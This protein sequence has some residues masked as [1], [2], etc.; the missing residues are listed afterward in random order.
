MTRRIKT[1]FLVYVGAL[2]ICGMMLSTICSYVISKHAMTHTIEEEYVQLVNSLTD[3]VNIWLHSILLTCSDWSERGLFIRALDDS[4]LGKSMHLPSNKVLKKYKESYGFYE[5]ISLV[6]VL[7]NVVCSS[8]EELIENDNI[9]EKSFFTEYHCSHSSEEMANLKTRISKIFK[10]KYTGK[11]V[12][13][14]AVPIFSNAVEKGGII[15]VIDLKKMSDSFV[16]R[17]KIGETGYCYIVDLNGVVLVHPNESEIGVVNL[18]DYVFDGDVL[19]QKEGLLRYTYG[20]QEKIVFFRRD[21]SLNWIFVAGAATEEIFASVNWVGF[22]NIMNTLFFIILAVVGITI[23]YN[24]VIAKQIKTLI[25][26]IAKYTQ[27]K[28]SVR[29]E[30]NFYEEFNEIVVSFNR[31]ADSLEHS[32]VSIEDLEVS[33]RRFGDIVGATG[34][35]IWELDAKGKYTYSSVMVK[36]VLGYLPEE[37]VGK[38]CYEFFNEETEEKK[39]Q[40]A[41]YEIFS[42]NQ[43]RISFRNKLVKKNGDI[44]IVETNGVAIFNTEKKIIGYR[45]VDRDITKRVEEEEEKISLEK[46]LQQ[47]KKLESI[48]TLAAGIAHEIN[49]PIQFIGDNIHFLSDGL[50]DLFKLINNFSGLLGLATKDDKKIDIMELKQNYEDEID[51]LFLENEVPECIHQTEDGLARVSKIVGAM[52]SFSHISDERKQLSDI[53]KAIETA[54]IV[55]SNEWKY[56]AEIKMDFDQELPAVMCFVGDI[57]QVIMNMVLNATH[58]IEDLKSNSKGTITITTSFNEKAVIIAITDTGKGIP[59]EIHDKILLPFFTTKEVGKG[60]GQGLSMAYSVIVEKHGGKLTF[61]SV[62]DKGTTFFIELP[63]SKLRSKN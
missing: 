38:Y 18:Y 3:N 25:A 58:A 39:F 40:K 54:V 11:Y 57:N 2:I 43:N 8:A 24:R 51:L 9:A 4:Y 37:M 55:S 33:Q 7:G 41:V 56:V 32:M 47:S 49:T 50:N 21:D 29:I 59:E 34:D 26:G 15:G 45:G 16:G 42:R 14:V 6:D 22:I 13:A 20:G 46:D 62:V 63:L 10:S 27:G 31:M 60:T 35:W 44:V 30:A 23:L 1:T 53:N 17:S 36:R 48:G 12:I 5:S 28:Q 61:D 52:K 19:S